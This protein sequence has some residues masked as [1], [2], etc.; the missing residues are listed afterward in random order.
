M[1]GSIDYLTIRIAY[2]AGSFNNSKSCWQQ[3]ESLFG[4]HQLP[5]V[6]CNFVNHEHTDNLTF[7]IQVKKIIVKDISVY[8]LKELSKSLVCSW[9]NFFLSKV[10]MSICG[11]WGEVEFQ[12]VKNHQIMTRCVDIKKMVATLVI[13]TNI[14]P[15]ECY[16]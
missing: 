8:F 12:N 14:W 6:I 13:A 7:F 2:L 5:A 10:W 15:C 1:A 9:Q 16:N 11:T 3:E 4:L